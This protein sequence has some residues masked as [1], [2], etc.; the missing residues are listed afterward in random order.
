MGPRQYNPGQNVG[1]RSA[2]CD[3][4]YI[5]RSF[6]QIACGTH[7]LNLLEDSRDEEIKE[8]LLHRNPRQVE[9]LALRAGEYLI[10]AA[11]AGRNTPRRGCIGLPP[12]QGVSCTRRWALAVD[13]NVHNLI[14]PPWLMHISAVL[15]RFIKFVNSLSPHEES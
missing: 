12:H 13:K 14:V 3:S 15:G 4:H 5:K 9:R 1:H 6:E 11:S 8:Q 7:C 2:A 10:T